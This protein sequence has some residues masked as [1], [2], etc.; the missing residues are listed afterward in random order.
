MQPFRSHSLVLA[1]LI[2]KVGIFSRFLA[3]RRIDDGSLAN[4]LE[5]ELSGECVDLVRITD[6]DDVCNLVCK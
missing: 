5:A 3:C 1:E 4:V 2:E 6:E